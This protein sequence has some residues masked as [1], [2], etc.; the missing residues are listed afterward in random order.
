M[1][2]IKSKY[3]IILTGWEYHIQSKSLNKDLVET[4]P[5]GGPKW[6]DFELFSI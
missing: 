2:L 4:V 3:E 6:T 1:G 5:Q